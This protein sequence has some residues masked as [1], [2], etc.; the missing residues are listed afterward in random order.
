MAYNDKSLSR[1]GVGAASGSGGS[2]HSASFMYRTADTKATIEGTG[3]F[4]SAR[5]RVKK[6]DILFA[7]TSTGGTPVLTQYVFTSV[8]TSGNVVIAAESNQAAVDGVAAGYKVARGVSAVTGTLAVTTG[9]ATVVACV[10][11]LES[12]PVVGEAMGCSVDIPTQTGDDA[13]KVTL[14]TWK[15]TANDNATPVAG[16]GTPN[17]SWIA[18]GT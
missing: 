17:V 7:V 5:T 3:Y 1:Q 9:L 10:A 2:E 14:K 6:G 12:D 15:P 8:P 4:N 13:G 11:G 18:I 16:T